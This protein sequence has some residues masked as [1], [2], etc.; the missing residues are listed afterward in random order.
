MYGCIVQSKSLFSTTIDNS[1][2][3]KEQNVNPSTSLNYKDNHK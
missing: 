3:D 2:D 1:T